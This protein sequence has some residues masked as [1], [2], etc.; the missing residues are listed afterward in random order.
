MGRFVEGVEIVPGVR[1]TWDLYVDAFDPEAAGTIEEV[2]RFVRGQP[3]REVLTKP[4]PRRSASTLVWAL[5]RGRS[6]CLSVEIDSAG[7]WRRVVS[8]RVSQPERE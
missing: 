5:Y 2:V 8:V 1:R 7:T 4:D 6:V 3:P